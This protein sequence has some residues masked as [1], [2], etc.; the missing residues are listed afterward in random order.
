MNEIITWGAVETAARIKAKTVSASDVTEAHL[1]HIT[2]CEPDL[3]AVVEV[4]ADDARKTVCAVY[5]PLIW[6]LPSIFSLLDMFSIGALGGCY[7]GWKWTC[8]SAGDC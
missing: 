4:L 6:C 2:K 1:D 3:N 7:G 5:V 8:G